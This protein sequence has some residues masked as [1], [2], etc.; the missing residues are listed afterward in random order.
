MIVLKNGKVLLE[1]KFTREDVYISEGR[2]IS[3]PDQES[4]AEVIDCDNK[5]VIPGLVDIHTHGC[6]GYDFCDGTPEA[7]QAI[8]AYEMSQGVMAFL[9]TSMTLSKDNLISIFENARDF[10]REKEN[11]L[12]V[13]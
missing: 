9:P 3:A 6:F 1:G 13:T 10:C 7:L 11:T 4:P 12:P 8:S 2:I 5:Y